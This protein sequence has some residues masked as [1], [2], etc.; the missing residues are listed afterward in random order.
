MN[1][2]LLLQEVSSVTKKY[3][4]LYQKT[5]GYFNVF[6]ILNTD[7]KE[8]AICK[9]LHDLLNPKGS[10]YQGDTYLKLFLKYVM[11]EIHLSDSEYEQIKVYREYL[12]QNNR[13]ID[14]FIQTPQ[15]AIP[16]EVKIFASDQKN[17]CADYFQEA[18]QSTVYYLTR[19][20]NMPSETSTQDMS[21]ITAIS[22]ETHILTWLSKCLEHKETIKI[23]PIREVLLQLMTVIRKFTNRMEDEQTMEVSKILASS[24]EHMKNA[25]M[26]EQSIKISK[27]DLMTSVFQTLEGRIPASK[28]EE[29]DD[30]FLNDR[31]LIKEYYNKEKSTLP[32]INYLYKDNVKPNISL[33][34]CIVIDW[35]IHAGLLYY[36]NR[37]HQRNIN[38]RRNKE[39]IASHTR[40]K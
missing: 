2:E 11:P 27:V 28:I 35:R 15:H 22:F 8:V 19:F 31:K 39:T 21:T 18:I 33:L 29:A 32:A 30:Y 7:T 5:G 6:E 24:S 23:A 26:I 13:R 37:R 16:I 3:D 40:T 34:F 38:G 14:L 4:L 1:T 9:V 10:H 20:G 25:V 17:Q 36:Q 12:V